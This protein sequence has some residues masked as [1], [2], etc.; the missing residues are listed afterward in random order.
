M[1]G[2]D[3]LNQSK[4][5]GFI[6]IAQGLY[7]AI[8]GIWP[9]LHIESFLAVTGPKEDIWLVRTFG[10]VILAVGLGLFT[11]G[12]KRAVS[13]PIAIIAMGTS[14]GLMVAEIIYVLQDVI[15][16]S[17]LLDAF[18]E[19]GLLLFWILIISGTL[20]KKTRH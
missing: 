8:T 6:L 19:A 20:D 9:L 1:I 5:A 16:P 12:M 18:I 15:W 2:T 14:L 3:K 7:F 10:I 17:Y 11:S 13:W 4:S